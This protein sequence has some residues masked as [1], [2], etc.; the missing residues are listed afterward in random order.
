MPPQFPWNPELEEHFLT[1]VLQK[2]MHLKGR[3]N[4]VAKEWDNLIVELFSDSLFLPHKAI[5][6]A[7]ETK[8]PTRKFRDHLQNTLARVANIISAGNKSAFESAEKSALVKV[9]EQI[10]NEIDEQA[11]LKEAEKI[12]KEHGIQ[13]QT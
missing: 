12:I 7:D 4:G 1:L 2:G 5:Y 8:P 10:N 11:E 3:G 6:F 9:A 13:L